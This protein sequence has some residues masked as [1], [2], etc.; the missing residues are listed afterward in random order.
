VARPGQ[1][2]L[3]VDRVVAERHSRLGLRLLHVADE[4]VGV[5]GHPH[6]TA[7]TTGRCLDEHRV[8][9]LRG[10]VKRLLRALHG[11]VGAGHARHAR[12]HH[13]VAR[14]GLVSHALDGLR[15][16]ADEGE[17]GVSA[18]AGEPGVLGEEPVAGVD[19]V[20]ARH[21]RGRDDVRD[22]QVALGGR[23]RPHADRLI[24]H[25]RVQAV[26]VGLGEDRHRA[27][28]EL[29]ACPYDAERDLAPVG[30]EY[31]SE[32]VHV[33]KGVRSRTGPGRTRPACNPRPRPP[34]RC[35]SRAPRS[36]S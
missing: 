17:T 33:R 16:R 11:A 10:E 24:G 27:D 3:D 31:L 21:Q 32:L 13:R 14:H 2:L 9:H 8:T 35:P 30:D 5:P 34:A 23:R 18:G 7:P 36:R 22:V 28:A 20:R 19:G 29:P 4:L 26:P 12:R 15:G 1:V 6:A 25:S